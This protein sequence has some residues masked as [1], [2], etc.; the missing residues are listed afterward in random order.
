MAAAAMRRV[1]AKLLSGSRMRRF[2]R[3]DKGATAVEFSLVALPF[4][5][6]LF[7]I[8]ET[9]MVFYAS[10]VL[11]TAAANASRLILTGQ[12]TMQNMNAETF[13]SEVCKNL[14]ALFDCADGVYVDV[15]TYTSFSAVDNT[16]P[17]KDGKIDTSKLKFGSG[18]P[19]DIVVMKLY[20]EW[21]IYASLLNLGLDSLS[22]GK[23]LLVATSAFR[24]E[25]FR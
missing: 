15:R 10:Q 18:E 17:V 22:K 19:N 21:P 9:A 12:A 23:R 7:A 5:A 8:I 20:Y 25:P 14:P 6:M 2:V 24:N 1:G 3:H 11:E 4:L 13:K 16:N